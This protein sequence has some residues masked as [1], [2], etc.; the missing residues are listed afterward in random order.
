MVDDVAAGQ[1]GRGSVGRPSL[2][3]LHSSRTGAGAGSGVAAG[4]GLGFSDEV[5][6]IVAARARMLGEPIRVRLLVLLDGGDLSVQQL[7]DHL[8]LSHQTVSKHL[9]VLYLAGMVNRRKEGREVLY[10]LVDYVALWVI[11]QLAN[12]AA[13]HAE[14]L[15]E[16]FSDES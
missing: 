6:E 10:A 7:A 3:S 1:G 11:Q 13:D 8:G 9:N 14:Q 2:R 12:S 15:H 4:R 16:L 5:L